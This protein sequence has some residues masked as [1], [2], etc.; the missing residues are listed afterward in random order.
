MGGK[1]L[2]AVVGVG[3][4]VLI[5]ACGVI[6]LVGGW[7]GEAATVAQEEFG[8]RALLQ[9]Y[10]SFKDM[11]A[12]LAAKQAN[13]KAQQGKIKGLEDAY[14][15]ESRKDWDRVDKQQHSQWLAEMDGQKL[16]FNN[17]AAQYNAAMAKLN[18][19][20]CNVGTLPEGA[21]EPLPREYAPYIVQ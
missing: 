13:I 16:N 15:G 10:E 5:P 9:K 8:P 12:Q 11:H 7:F 14:E 1:T 6:K 3:L 20:F 2:L 4:L 18:Y 17:L 19:K 21:T